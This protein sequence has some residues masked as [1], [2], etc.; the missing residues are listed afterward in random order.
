MIV[1]INGC[2]T[3]IASI[4][5]ALERL[6]KK[7]LLTNNVTIIKSAS[8]VILPGVN[9]AKQAMDQLKKLQLID[10]IRQLKKPV[11]GI[12]SGMQILYEFSYE[13]N[14]DCLGV[15]KG[16]IVTLPKLSGL[17]IPHM[18]WNQLQ[19]NNKSSPLLKNIR[20]GSYVY[21]VHSYR[22]PL[23]KDTVAST[24]YGDVFSSIVQNQNFYG[25]Q[26]HPERSGRVG[27]TILANFLELE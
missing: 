9:T 12:C 20:D 5:F 21:Y 8:H 16:E 17:P 15:L 25:V 11:L 22:A 3:N 6:G 1:I 13:N 27:E 10:A 18:G 2:G 26:F 24:K 23:N 4:Q 14:I 19:I 7:S